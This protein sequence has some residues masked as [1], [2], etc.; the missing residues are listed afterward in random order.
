MTEW[1]R[2][3]ASVWAKEKILCRLEESGL[4]EEVKGEVLAS[5]LKPTIGVADLEDKAY[6]IISSSSE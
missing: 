4:S 2:L 5:L 3:C 1:K 6:E